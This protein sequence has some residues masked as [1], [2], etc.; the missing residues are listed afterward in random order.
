MDQA[1]EATRTMFSD[2]DRFIIL[3]QIR[4]ATNLLETRIK[5]SPDDRDSWI[6]LLA[7]YREEGMEGG[8]NR[9]YAAFCEHF[10]NGA[11]S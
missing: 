9:T 3:G 4:N 5:R 7:I 8:F 11:D 1:L 10:G 2:V 6:K